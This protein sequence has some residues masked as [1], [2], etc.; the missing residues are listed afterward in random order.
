MKKS[1]IFALVFTS[2]ISV[3]ASSETVKCIQKAIPDKGYLVEMD[4]DSAVVSEITIAGP[5]VIANLVC[6]QMHP[7]T[8]PANQILNVF[9][10]SEPSLT[11]AGYSFDLNIDALSSQLTGVL[12]EVH[13]KDLQ[14][15]ANLECESL[16]D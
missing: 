9:K 3:F 16:N 11:D 8:V 5:K 10:C 12:S 2:T 6:S 1:F 13:I 14:T 7:V 4:K 15:V